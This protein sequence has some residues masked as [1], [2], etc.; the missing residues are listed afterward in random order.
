MKI[1]SKTKIIETVYKT[2]ISNMRGEYFWDYLH[3]QITTRLPQYRELT[4]IQKQNKKKCNTISYN[5]N[6]LLLSISIGI[7]VVCSFCLAERRLIEIG[8]KTVD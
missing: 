7:V 2:T 6:R 5:S 4:S 8:S 3:H 1:T